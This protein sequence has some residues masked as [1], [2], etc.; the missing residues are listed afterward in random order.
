[1]VRII[2]GHGFLMTARPPALAGRLLPSLST[3]SAS[4]PR[5][6]LVA[7]PGFKGPVGRG[8]IRMDTVSVCLQVSMIGLYPPAARWK[9]YLAF[10]FIRSPTLSQ[11]MCVGWA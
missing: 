1:M 9:H 7:V 5:K 2:E 8:V 3:T 6:G 10:G 4:M 11:I